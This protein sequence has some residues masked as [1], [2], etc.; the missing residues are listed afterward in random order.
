M[1]NT[2]KRLYDTGRLPVVNLKNAVTLSWITAEQY[3]Q[4]TGETYSA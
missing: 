2:L 3:Q 1:Y 4:I